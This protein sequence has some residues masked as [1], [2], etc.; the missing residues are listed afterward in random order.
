LSACGSPVVQPIQVGA[1]CPQQPLRSANAEAAE[2]PD[3]LID[4]FEDGDGVVARVGGRD[5]PWVEGDDQTATT[6]GW[7]NSTRCAVRGTHAG[8]FFASNLT[9]WGANLT[10]VFKHVTTT[11]TPPHMVA[12]P[13]D[14]NGYGGISFW[15][16]IGSG[17]PPSLD[18][19]LGVTTMDTAWNGDVCT[20]KCM[21]FH[22][23]TV[24]LTPA[25]RRVEIRFSD[26][27]QM[28]WGDPLVAINVNQLVG[29]ILWPSSP[30]D[31]DLWIDD[32]R[33]EP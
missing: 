7:E 23:A 24:T 21:D 22:R 1:G 12:T 8:H 16:A 30:F 25:W 31:F 6:V 4:D 20:T 19:P 14:A 13:Y 26:L 9:A 17:G 10:G 29:F 3:N 32:I 5:G 2:P 33:F 11:G 15:G 27:K 18:V 28:G